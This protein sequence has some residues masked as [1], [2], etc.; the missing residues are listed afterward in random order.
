MMGVVTT[1]TTTTAASKISL[2]CLCLLGVLS[3]SLTSASAAD[4]ELNKVSGDVI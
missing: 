3:P 4:D 1:T 2:L